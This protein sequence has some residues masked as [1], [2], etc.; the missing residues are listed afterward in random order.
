MK[1][2]ILS[3]LLTL[4]LLCSIGAVGAFA[5]STPTKILDLNG[6]GITFTPA[7]YTVDK[8]NQTQQFDFVGNY[9]LSGKAKWIAFT[10]EN[11]VYHL[12]VH[13]FTIQSQE[14]TA[15]LLKDNNITLNV[16]MYGLFFANGKNAVA[17][18]SEGVSGGKIKVTFDS[19]SRLYWV[20]QEGAPVGRGIGLENEKGEP[21]VS[22]WSDPTY[23]YV[24][25]TQSPYDHE[26]AVV[27]GETGCV[28]ACEHCDILDGVEAPHT[29]SASGKYVDDQ[30][31]ER[32]C[33]VCQQP[34]A[35]AHTYAA[36]RYV[37]DSTCGQYC[38]YCDQVF[39]EHGHSMDC[40]PAEGGHI[41]YC[42]LC[43]HEWDEVLPHTSGYRWGDAQHC[44]PACVDCGEVLGDSI[45]HAYEKGLYMD[46]T[47][48]GCI[49]ICDNCNEYDYEN[50]PETVP[51]DFS[52][53]DIY[54]NSNCIS[55]CN[56]CG[57]GQTDETGDYVL[58]PH[59]FSDTGKIVPAT[60][61]QEEHTLSEC[62]NCGYTDVEYNREKSILIEMPTYYYPENNGS[63]NEMGGLAVYRNGVLWKH[64]NNVREDT[65][66]LPFDKNASYVFKLLNTQTPEN[67]LHIWM[68]DSVQPLFVSQNL[69]ED[70]FE[71]YD[72]VATYNLADYSLLQKALDNVPADM[73]EYTEE[74]ALKV[75]EAVKAIERMLPKS[76]QKAV[77]D[78][79]EKVEAAVAGLEKA[80]PGTPAHGVVHLKDTCV[81]IY[82][83]N[84]VMY[85]GETWEE[86]YTREYTG[87]YFLF[88][89][90]VMDEVGKEDYSKGAFW[91]YDGAQKNIDI[92]N[93]WS[94][95]SYGV[96]GV[97]DNS[98]AILT[99]HGNNVIV[100][101]TTVALDENGEEYSVTEY[102]GIGVPEGSEITV[103]GSGSLVALGQDNCAGIGGDDE[104]N[105]GTVTINSGNIFALS[106]GDGAGIGGGYKGGAGTVTINGGTV[107][108]N[109]LHD[110]GTGIGTGDDGIGGT[111][112]IHGG[113]VTALS[114]DDDGSGIGSGDSGHIDSITI[115]GGT[116]VAGA[117]DG[118][119]IGGGQEQVSYGGKITVNGGVVLP[120]VYHD[121]DEYF[122][123]NGNSSSKG[124]AEDNFVQINGG[125]VITQGTQGIYP[126]K[127]SEKGIE[128][129]ATDIPA[130]KG[131]EDTPFNV[132]LEDGSLFSLIPEDGKATVV[133]SPFDYTLVGDVNADGQINAK[134]ALETLKI[135]VGKRQSNPMEQTASDVNKDG[136]SNAKDALEM[137]KYTVGKPSVLA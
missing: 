124:L 32:M 13:E 93:L 114:L 47:P 109:C 48:T 135:S 38:L 23:F 45:L 127:E 49:P 86:M 3:I 41:A 40:E 88:G 58:T 94:V 4:C 121:E 68:P 16:A 15:L 75:A 83:E 52:A 136:V 89:T 36:C 64:V 122:I 55:V 42:Y 19:F 123:G 57:C 80:A 98:S 137:L 1:K 82:P 56:R 24:T 31:C 63:Y 20:A 12:A 107:Y 96:A 46:V 18:H 118:A 53:Y 119:A 100:D 25:G 115:N 81:G 132:V 117:E 50:P 43:G 131:K 84:Y 6:E 69:K 35:G 113:N 111:V 34:V 37:D 91:L 134:D 90:N 106:A 5:E 112:T 103:E 33:E 10:G 72:T 102:A 29:L 59:K 120:H 79:A 39:F 105:A 104:E 92:A 62:E 73:S 95:G 66:A 26:T 54:D 76:K 8:D 14:S 67:A 17:G 22:E 2:R 65:V 51:H 21:L 74:S 87:D 30:T 133:A 7:G 11:A 71:I 110:D 61:W 129:T 130:P 9:I 116:V 108:A 78:M 60:Q 28:Y 126:L 125:V 44:I 70:G 128:V 77:N 85:H 101:G 99:L 27:K 97:S